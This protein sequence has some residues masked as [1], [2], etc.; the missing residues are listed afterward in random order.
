MGE[1]DASSVNYGS[2]P[3]DALD[4]LA[5]ACPIVGSYGAKDPTL[6]KAPGELERILTTHGIDHDIRVYA[7]AGHSFLNEHT[8]GE[9]PPWALV[10]GKLSHT[11]YH[12][13][14]AMDA[15]RRILDFFGHHLH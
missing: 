9:E 10:A 5:G 3:K 15:R 11:E 7:D 2:V 6:R 1:Y 8:P 13:P 4:L 14:S 12:E